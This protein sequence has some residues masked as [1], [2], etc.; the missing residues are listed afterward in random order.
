MIYVISYKTESSDE[1]VIFVESEREPTDNQVNTLLF[2]Y[3]EDEYLY[4]HEYSVGW[5]LHPSTVIESVPSKAKI[6]TFL[7]HCKKNG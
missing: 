7:D 4:G 5:E 3:M 6:K 1:G 2:E